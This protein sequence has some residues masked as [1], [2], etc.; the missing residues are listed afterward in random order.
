MTWQHIFSYLT[1]LFCI[2]SSSAFFFLK[3]NWLIL[4]DNFS[5]VSGSTFS[6]ICI[7][8]NSAGHFLS[9]G[10]FSRKMLLAV[11]RWWRHCRALLSF[12]ESEKT[13]CSLTCSSSLV[14]ALSDQIF[15]PGY[16]SALRLSRRV[17]IRMS[18]VPCFHFSQ[19]LA[20]FRPLNLKTCWLTQQSEFCLHRHNSCDSVSLL[21]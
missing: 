9:A 18:K 20:P 13:F 15:H 6:H 17:S 7:F 14:C 16:F 1:Q 2:F 8:P 10:H 19:A 12:S 21:S 5:S 11:H 3:I 4:Y